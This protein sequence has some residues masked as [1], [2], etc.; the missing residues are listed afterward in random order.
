MVDKSVPIGDTPVS[1]VSEQELLGNVAAGAGIYLVGWGRSDGDSSA[2]VVTRLSSAG[3]VLD[4]HGIVVPNSEKSGSYAPNT[5]VGFDGTNF[6]VATW[7]GLALLTPQGEWLN[8]PTYLD[9]VNPMR[10]VCM[11]DGNCYGLNDE[12]DTDR[13]EWV[14]H[15]VRI[16]QNNQLAD[17]PGTAPILEEV[18]APDSFNASARLVR[19]GQ[20]VAYVF[21]AFEEQQGTKLKIWVNFFDPASGKVTP[22]LEVAS[23]STES[24]DELYAVAGR[25]GEALFVWAQRGPTDGGDYDWMTM[26][27]RIGSDGKALEPAR[28]IALS[29]EDS[30]R[31]DSLFYTGSDYVLGLRGTS[32]RR[33]SDVGELTNGTLALGRDDGPELMSLAG[34]GDTM[35]LATSHASE[36][37]YPEDVRLFTKLFQHSGEELGA[38]RPIEE[39]INHMSEPAVAWGGQNYFAVWVDDRNGVG[40]A[41]LFG[42]RVAPDG[43]QLDTPALLLGA[44]SKT[45]QSKPAIASSGNGYLVV[46]HAA[47]YLYHSTVWA[48]Y[49]DAEG[50]AAPGAGITWSGH[51]LSAPAVA[52]NGKSYLA[53]WINNDRDV[54]DLYVTRFGEKGGRLDDDTWIATIAVD[55]SGS[56]GPTLAATNDGFFLSWRQQ[57]G[58][59]ERDVYGVWLEESKGALVATTAPKSLTGGTF[60]DA[61][62]AYQDTGAA[63]SPSVCMVAWYDASGDTKFRRFDSEGEALGPTSTLPQVLLRPLVAWDGK[64]FLISNADSHVVVGYVTEAGEPFTP[65]FSPASPEEVSG[66]ALAT[67]GAGHGLIV[68]ASDKDHARFTGI[69]VSEDV[70]PEAEGGSG[71]QPAGDPG[72]MMAGT[73]GAPL[74]GAATNGG[75]SDAEA[76]QAGETSAGSG[77]SSAAAMSSPRKT[78]KGCG[79]SVPGG[80]TSRSPWLLLGL[81]GVF[82]RRRRQR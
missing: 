66:V 47:E 48:T 62:V 27:R 42:A 7:D 17:A 44:G 81:L 18:D 72:T 51:P 49:V 78:D 32:L 63:C 31:I 25:D 60:V 74:A 10:V 71:G 21:S 28:K 59:G 3:E 15:F 79:C 6:R 56:F 8:A 35:L 64:A 52:W 41:D 16:D 34:T 33:L 14:R 80:D 75:A 53:A 12:Y 82:A 23:G 30:Q 45:W 76:G 46:D 67:D 38:A 22:P 54:E 39:G 58:G 77:G 40:R 61:S 24:L 36:A 13:N 69:L 19:V 9:R 20:R 57:A 2:S 4:P 65:A 43:T 70:A 11:D 37:E 5:W 68:T 26:A 55:L 1:P 29:A 73:S 50:V